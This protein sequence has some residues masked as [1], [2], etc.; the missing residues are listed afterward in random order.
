MRERGDLRVFSEP[1]SASYYLSEG[2]VSDRFAQPT[3]HD[4]AP[5][6]AEVAEDL[7]TAAED[8]TVFVKDMAYHVA[9]CL[10]RDFVARYQNT[11]IIRHPAR[12]L[13]SLRDLLPDFTAEE[14]GFEQQERLM[15]LA[16]QVSPDGLAVVDGDQ[17]RRSPAAAV[18]AYC[19][20]VGLPHLPGSLRWEADLLPDWER[21]APW[22]GDVA[23]STGIHPPARDAPEGPPRGVDPELYR[24][25]LDHYERMIELSRASRAA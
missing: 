19:R 3:P 25:C 17:L 15:R 20:R 4:P 7:A 12:T 23:A 10:R 21:W 6:W 16:L 5:S 8:Q 18:E 2:R 1:F 11:F 13:P 24:R 9:P 22:H 14:T